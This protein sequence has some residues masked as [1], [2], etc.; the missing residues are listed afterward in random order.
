MNDTGW[1]TIYARGEQLNRYPFSEVVSFFFRNREER[2]DNTPT[3]LDVGC[4]SGIHSGFL[5]DHGFQVLGIDAS[6]AAIVA[7]RSTHRHAS[8]Q[9]SQTRFDDFDAGDRKFD[10]VVD[11]CSTTHSTVLITER[12]YE[13]LQSWLNPGARIFWQ[14]FAWGNSG[15]KLG[16]EMD[17]GSWSDFSGG[18]FAPLGRT[19]FFKEDDI[20]RIFKKYQLRSLRHLSDC[21]VDTEY[22]HSSWIVEASFDE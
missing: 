3:A 21:D 20:R 4:G 10:I 14:G 7:A 11:R 8:I 12:F 22:D 18:V 9:F 17:D 19:A 6:E 1:E 16:S 13:R 5:A 2:P 15:R